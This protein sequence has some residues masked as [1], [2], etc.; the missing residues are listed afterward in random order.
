MLASCRLQRQ[1]LVNM[2]PNPLWMGGLIQP[3][4]NDTAWY[5]DG[6]LMDTWAS[7]G[8]PQAP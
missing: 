4:L 2:K 5:V 7:V 8:Q 1:C 3:T 6:M